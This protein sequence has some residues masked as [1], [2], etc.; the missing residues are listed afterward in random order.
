MKE[1]RALPPAVLVAITVLVAVQF[2]AQVAALV[3]VVRTPQSRISLGGRKWIWILIIVLGE[4]LGPIVYSA[5]GRLPV[6][7]D[8]RPVTARA[9]GRAAAAADTLYGAAPSRAAF[10][11]A[12]LVPADDP[13]LGAD[14]TGMGELP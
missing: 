8:D 1:L 14:G 2:I 6:P 9:E 4:I 3:S 7:A 10:D 11:D 5:A 12:P 13:E